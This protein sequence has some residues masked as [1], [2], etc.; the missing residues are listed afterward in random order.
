MTISRGRKVFL[1]PEQSYTICDTGQEK[2]T[3]AIYIKRGDAVFVHLQICNR[4]RMDC[5]LMAIVYCA[6][7]AGAHSH[8]NTCVVLLWISA[9][10]R[11]GGG[12]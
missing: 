2:L 4:S 10:R 6:I 11:G 1:C 5:Q 3:H 7:F 9:L 12:M 8:R